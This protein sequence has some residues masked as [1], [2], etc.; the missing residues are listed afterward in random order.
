MKKAANACGNNKRGAKRRTALTVTAIALFTVIAAALL[1]AFINPGQSG[2]VPTPPE[3]QSAASV[4]ANPSPVAGDVSQAP[5]PSGIQEAQEVTQP[6]PV[7]ESDPPSEDESHN[8]AGKPEAE[9]PQP[10][11]DNIST[12]DAADGKEIY[13][14]ASGLTLNAA[15]VYYGVYYFDSGSLSTSGNSAKTPSASV[16]KVFIMEYAFYQNALGLLDLDEALGGLTVLSQITLMIQ[17]S[18]NN[19]TNALID[20]FGMDELNAFFLQRGYG[21]TVLDRRM[22]DF[23]R[24]AAGF[25]NYTSLE[26]CMAFL[27]KL[28]NNRAEEPYMHM[29][30]IM[31]GQQVRTKIPLKL[32]SG[33]IAASKTGELDDVENDIGIVFAENAPF[34]IVVLS[35]GALST[36]NM[37]NAIADFALEAY[38]IV[39][40]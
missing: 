29:I 7:D 35:S 6:P 14:D 3:T 33:V 36:A 8:A 23:D 1:Y 31:K 34:A 28:F 12:S 20:F 15:N 19:A 32:P 37:R 5:E 27:I 39:T 13:I 4:T 11:D 2:P 38:N 24:R 18:D 26:D 17:Q 25:D 30:E 16:I 9:P 22:L 10:S 21:D 40:E